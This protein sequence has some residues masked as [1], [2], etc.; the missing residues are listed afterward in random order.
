MTLWGYKE[1]ECPL[2]HATQAEV[3]YALLLLRSN[4]VKGMLPNYSVELCKNYAL[5]KHGEANCIRNADAG[6]LSM[7]QDQ[8]TWRTLWVKNGSL[9][10]GDCRILLRLEP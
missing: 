8:G 4:M 3:S 2:S 7:N 10:H 9:L 5:E 1:T 6:W